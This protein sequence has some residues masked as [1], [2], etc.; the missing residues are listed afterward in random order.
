MI[1]AYSILFSIVLIIII[2][3]LFKKECSKNTDCDDT[4]SCSKNKCVDNCT[5]ESCDETNQICDSKT[6]K[7]TDC[8]SG[9]NW[10]ETGC[11]NPSLVTTGEPQSEE[12]S[13]DNAA[14]QPG[15]TVV[16]TPVTTGEPQSGGTVAPE[17]WKS[18]KPVKF[19]NDETGIKVYKVDTITAN[20]CEDGEVAVQIEGSSSCNSQSDFKGCID[21]PEVFVSVDDG[22]KGKLRLGNIKGEG[23][24]YKITK[25]LLD[26][27]SISDTYN[28]TIVYNHEGKSYLMRLKDNEPY[29]NEWDEKEPAIFACAKQTGSIKEVS[30]LEKIGCGKDMRKSKGICCP[31]GSSN[32]NGMCCTDG[33]QGV[34]G[35]FFGSEHND[36]GLGICC[37]SS[38][39]AYTDKA[40]KKQCCESGRVTPSGTC[41]GINSKITS[42]G[43]CCLMNDYYKED[44]LD[45][46]CLG[47]PYGIYKNAAGE[48][49]CCKA[50][51]KGIYENAD[52]QQ[53]CCK[54]KVFT[55]GNGTRICCPHGQTLIDG[56]CCP[57][58]KTYQ[59]KCYP[60]SIPS[61]RFSKAPKAREYLNGKLVDANYDY[62]HWELI[63]NKN[64][65]Y[66]WNYPLDV[67][68]WV[69]TK[70][71]K[72]FGYDPDETNTF[73]I[74]SKDGINPYLKYLEACNKI[75]NCYA[76]EC[77]EDGKSC[78]LWTHTKTVPDFKKIKEHT[79]RGSPIRIFPKKV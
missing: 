44:G 49:E 63:N 75:D 71:D 3:F 73:V 1:I 51:A 46:C 70:K 58:D 20:K 26:G 40:G 11:K 60:N 69:K 23:K 57:N 36:Q 33:R 16:T 7:C 47:G 35:H 12:Q 41:C 42:D 8:P 6:F 53:E 48:K 55:D 24:N 43:Y 76:T 5:K 54:G 39:K 67:N 37:T 19:K 32:S 10:S 62:P 13:G 79:T 56:K 18:F 61:T 65:L 15:V 27:R 77:T 22:V 64:T 45:L 38:A 66:K 68:P 34:G 31:I 28:F 52:G 74:D 4:Q 25:V 72:V 9:F 59:G 21:F 30:V 2:Y 78:R 50:G 14:T 17:F 29:Y